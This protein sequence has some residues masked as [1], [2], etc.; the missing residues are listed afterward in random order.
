MYILKFFIKM[1]L[2]VCTTKDLLSCQ[3]YINE[4]TTQVIVSMLS[5][6]A[7]K[8]TRMAKPEYL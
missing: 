2:Y 8:V 7:D 6:G 5:I 4:P 3:I 1:V